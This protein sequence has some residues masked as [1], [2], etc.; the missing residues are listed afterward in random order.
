M[1]CGSG[2]ARNCEY[3][4]W[5]VVDFPGSYDLTVDSS[6]LCLCVNL[7]DLLKCHGLMDMNMS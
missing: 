6:C 7:T 3:N 2:D 5:S 1:S 4:V